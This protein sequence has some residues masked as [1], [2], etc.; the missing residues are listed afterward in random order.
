MCLERDE[1]YLLTICIINVCLALF[2]HFDRIIINEVKVVG[3]MRDS[4]AHDPK[5]FKILQYRILKLTLKK[6]LNTPV[7]KE[8]LKH[9]N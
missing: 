5:N 4:L 6:R 1:T 2:D 7:L 9:T 3:C 8:Y